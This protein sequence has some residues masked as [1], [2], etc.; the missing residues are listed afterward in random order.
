MEKFR[1][2]DSL[3][4]GYAEEM[5]ELPTTVLVSCWGDGCW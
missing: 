3:L 2:R 1:R 4:G 5:A